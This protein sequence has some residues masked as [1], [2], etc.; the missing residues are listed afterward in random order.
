MNCAQAVEAPL[1]SSSSRM[2]QSA[3][4]LAALSSAA[5][6]VSHP[7]RKASN[8][9]QAHSPGIVTAPHE[10]FDIRKRVFDFGDGKNVESAERID[11][12]FKY[13]QR[14]AKSS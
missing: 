10:V 5:S 9:L 11:R 14:P 1:L 13:K 8:E 6:T 7:V 4:L 12:L 2:I 3:E